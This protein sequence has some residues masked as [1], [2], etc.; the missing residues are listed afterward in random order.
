[1][2]CIGKAND[3]MQRFALMRDKAVLSDMCFD[4]EREAQL[5]F[6]RGLV[7]IN[8]AAVFVEETLYAALGER[9]TMWIFA[10]QA[11][12]G[13][14]RVAIILDSLGFKKHKDERHADISAVHCLV[15]VICSGIV[16]HVYVDFVDTW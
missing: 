7:A 1:M 2:I 15:E 12:I 4:W 6:H 8:A 3:D 14:T 16:V 13:D 9:D 11:G 5:N 10:Y